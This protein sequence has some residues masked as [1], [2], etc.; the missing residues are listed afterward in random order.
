MNVDLNS[1]IAPPE[2][3]QE[4]V[5]PFVAAGTVDVKAIV[6]SSL[7]K[8]ESFTEIA[9]NLGKEWN[10]EK[11]ERLCRSTLIETELKK[12]VKED[13]GELTLAALM[14]VQ[15]F[16]AIQLIGRV[17]KDPTAPVNAQITA[18][19]TAL[20]YVMVPARDKEFGKRLKGLGNLDEVQKEAKN[21]LAEREKLQKQA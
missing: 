4:N 21:L 2:K 11:V 9:K 17:L 20:E 19:R 6:V 1:L 3:S 5:M 13:N 8:G 14:R 12:H 10:A 18:A 16:E 7:L 15:A